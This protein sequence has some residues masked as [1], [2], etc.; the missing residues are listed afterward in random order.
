MINPTETEI[1]GRWEEQRGSVVKDPACQR[2]KM[3]IKDYLQ[4]ITRSDDGWS[5]SSAFYVTGISYDMDGNLAALNRRHDGLKEYV[6][7]P[8]PGSNRV[9]GITKNGVNTAFGY[10][11]NGNVTT[12]GSGY[13][14]TATT[15][16]WRNLPLSITA[17][18]NTH[19]YKYDH[20]GSRVHK[21][22]GNTFYVRGAFGETLA[23]YSGSTVQWNLFTPAGTVIGRREGSNRLYY[24]RDHLGS[25][26][27]VVNASGTVVETQ[28]YYPYGLQMPGRSLTTGNSA[29]EKF[30]S[31]ELDTEVDL[32]Y[33]IARRYAPEF[34]RFMSVDPHTMNY[35]E[36]SSYNYVFN[37]PLS[38]VDPDGKDGIK[39]NFKLTGIAGFGSGGVNFSIGFDFQEL[40]IFATSGSSLGAGSTFGIG[41]SAVG[42]EIALTGSFYKGESPKGDKTSVSV[43]GFGGLISVSGSTESKNVVNI[44]TPGLSSVQGL[45]NAKDNFEIGLGAGVTTGGGVAV[46]VNE[47]NVIFNFKLG[48]KSTTPFSLGDQ[49]STVRADATNVVINLEKDLIKELKE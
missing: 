24:H 11:R 21:S 20:T 37:N 9:S 46:G 12:L 32:Y 31:H 6:Y 45:R 10:D 48:G 3:L 27:T 42:G 4:L 15:Y 2:I 17:A 23:V 1:T 8:T 35:P 25:T 47:E 22:S 18:G 30:T 16:N 5:S 19:S 28:D 33:M 29:R 41:G 36:W 26:R 38:Y 39:I 7:S 43:E 34:G 13:N 44:L 40:R 49:S 14:I